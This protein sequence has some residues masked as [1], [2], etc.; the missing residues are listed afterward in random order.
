M[1]LLFFT[2]NK[3]IYSSYFTFS[4]NYSELFTESSRIVEGYTDVLNR[5]FLQH[6]NTCVLRF[7]RKRI[8]LKNKRKGPAFKSYAQCALND[9]RCKSYK[10]TIDDLIKNGELTCTVYSNSVPIYHPAGE[11]KRRHNRNWNKKSL[12]EKLPNSANSYEMLD[13]VDENNATLADFIDVL[14]P[15]ALKRTTRSEQ[16]K[17]CK[18]SNS[19]EMAKL[20]KIQKKF[21]NNDSKNTSSENLNDESDS[22]NRESG[23]AD[24][25]NNNDKKLDDCSLTEEDPLNTS[26]KLFQSMHL[27][28][29]HVVGHT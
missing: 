16:K 2:D 6:N 12:D 15:K 26:S 18:M 17:K 3:R 21:D 19:D 24:L 8:N 28:G 29:Y 4:L 5:K 10:F 23:K 22:Q 11:S 9:S 14:S 27:I 20:I 13:N 1:F 7:L 25:E